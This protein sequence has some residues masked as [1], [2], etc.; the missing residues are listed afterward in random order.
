MAEILVTGG[1]GFIG[2]HLS[3]ALTARGDDVVGVDCFTDYYPRA[4]KERNLDE[5]RD[6]LDELDKTKPTVC[7]CQ[8]GLR[9]YAAV[10]ILKQHG[11]AEV[12]NLTGAAAQR[13]RALKPQ[14]VAS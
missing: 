12:Y 11:F 8:T 3:E 7:S 14:P 4:M 2:S 10:R 1:A 5:L 13:A 6:R 9:S